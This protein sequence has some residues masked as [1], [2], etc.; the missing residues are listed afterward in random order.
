[1]RLRRR[2]GIICL[3]AGALKLME[4]PMKKYWLGA[5]IIVLAL[6]MAAIGCGGEDD[7][8]YYTD[9]MTYAEYTAQNYFH[10]FENNNGYVLQNLNDAELETFLSHMPNKVNHD[11]V[12]DEVKSWFSDPNRGAFSSEQVG[13]VKADFDARE[14]CALICR[15]G[16]ARIDI[17]VKIK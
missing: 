5:V 1:L 9:Q 3:W 4:E 14:Q 12:D 16:G 8:K 13:S 6:G 7:G 15:T 2:R 11:W 10:V 17:L